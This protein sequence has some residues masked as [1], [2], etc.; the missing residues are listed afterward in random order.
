VV[1]VVAA[2][3]EAPLHP[4]HG[5]AGADEEKGQEPEEEDEPLP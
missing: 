2:L 3:D 4:P 1:L 5:N